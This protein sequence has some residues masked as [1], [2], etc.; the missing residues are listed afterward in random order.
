MF[1]L[2]TRKF[3]GMRNIALYSVSAPKDFYFNL[4]PRTNVESPGNEFDLNHFTSS[5]FLNKL[6]SLNILTSL[7]LGG[8]SSSQQYTDLVFL[9]HILALKNF[10][11]FIHKGSP[12][13]IS[14]ISKTISFAQL[15]LSHFLH[16][17]ASLTSV[18]DLT[19]SASKA[20]RN[21]YL[22]KH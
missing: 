11:L 19:P 6:G 1:S 20:K 17:Q 15:H 22:I 8:F 3:L 9:S 10:T 5:S 4:A 14:D 21:N 18:S 2:V 13:G 12:L 16:E 7:S